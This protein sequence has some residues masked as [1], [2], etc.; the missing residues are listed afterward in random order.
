MSDKSPFTIRL[1]LDALED[2]EAHSK[3]PFSDARRLNYA[4]DVARKTLTEI[5]KLGG[6][7]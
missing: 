4:N 5:R 3:P 7:V 2:I 6:G 1:A